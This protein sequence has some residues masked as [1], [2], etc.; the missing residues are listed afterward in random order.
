M[1]GLCMGFWA[2]TARRNTSDMEISR[3]SLLSRS[4]ERPQIISDKHTEPW[5]SASHRE[6]TCTGAS[7]RVGNQRKL[8][9]RDIYPCASAAMVGSDSVNKWGRGRCTEVRALALW[10]IQHANDEKDGE[11]VS[12]W[13]YFCGR[14]RAGSRNK[15]SGRCLQCP[16][17]FPSTVPTPAAP[18]PL[19]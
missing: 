1:I 5:R 17:V 6:R 18:N 12:M 9:S 3:T 8:S 7:V 2:A 11:Y 10:L 14:D 19:P 15:E 16:R 13:F 4:R